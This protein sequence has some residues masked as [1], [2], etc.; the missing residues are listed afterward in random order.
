MKV[1]AAVFRDKSGKASIETLDLEEPRDDEILVRVVAT[2]VCHTDIKVSTTDMSPRPIVLGHEGAGVVER[3]GSRVTKVR[4]GD[5]VVMTYD[6]CERCPSCL[7]NQRTYCDEVGPRSFGGNRPDGSSPLSQEGRKIH[8]SFFGQSSFADFALGYERNVVKVRKD[9]PLELL[10]P[11]GC[12]LQTGAGAAI[13]A[14]KVGVGQSFAV[15]GTGSVGLSAIMGARLMGAGRIIAVDVQPARLAAARELGATDTIDAKKQDALEAI[16][17]I[18]WR[19]VDFA[20]DTTG[21]APV[22]VQA[23][24]S[25]APLGTCGFVASP[26]APVG[27]Y[28]RDLMLGGRT[29]RGI[30]EGQSIPDLFIPAL[31]DFHLDGRFPLDKLATFYPFERINEAIHDSETASAIKPIL[32]MAG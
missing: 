7:A 1:K 28:I 24:K 23:V 22:I 9:V 3:V 13:N 14:L 21:L 27:I 12:G 15:F 31:I 30:V 29:L 11:L 17:A 19:G 8:G 26:A 6:A 10:G 25:L 18:S 20:L 5:H 4:P 2:G 32:R 16:K